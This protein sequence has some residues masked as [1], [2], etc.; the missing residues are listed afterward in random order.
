MNP[1]AEFNGSYGSFNT[2]KETVKVGTGLINNHWAFDARLSNIGTDGYIDRASSALGSYYLQGAYY[3]DNT[4]IKLISFA[5]KERTYHA[6][7]YASKDQ[8]AA[9]GRT[10]NSCGFM[11]MEDREGN[12]Y[13]PEI[14]Y[15]YGV[16]E[17]SDLLKKGA[18]F[19]FYNDQTDNY[20]QK[21]YQLL[22][23]HSF[24]PAWHLN[25]GLHY[26]KGDGYYQE[27]KQGR[28]LVQFGLVPFYNGETDEEGNPVLQKKSDL[29]RKKAMDNHFGGGIFSLDYKNDR[30]SASLG[31]A[32]NRYAGDHF[33]RVMWVKNYVGELDPDKDYYRSTVGKNDGSLYLKAGYDLGA[34]VSTYADMQYRHITYKINGRNDKW[35]AAEEQL[36]QLAID[37]KFGFFNPKAGLSWQIDRNNRLYGSFSVAHKEPTRNNYTDG[38]LKEHPKAERLFDYELGYN[39]ANH[40]LNLSANLY[41][42]DYK[43]Q[44]VL[45]G[46]MNE[47]GEAVAANV[48]DSY[49]MGVELMAGV[50][51]PCGF[52]WDINA[53]LS[54]NR[55]KNFTETLYE[56]EDQSTEAWKIERGDTPISFS[57]DFILNNRFG[58]SYRGFEA[59]LQSQYVSKQYMTNAKRDDQTLDA[60]FVSNLSLAYTFKLRGVKSVT[61]GCTVY[62]LFNEEY[63]NNGFAGSG[64]SRND[65][66]EKERYSYA[67]YAA[68]AGTNVLAHIAISF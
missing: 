61:V 39:F 48:P 26:T 10:F 20:I 56:W 19:H 12:V 30:L 66:G 47:I 28:K 21:N 53:T 11:F 34:G 50:K 22:L 5:G 4:S 14:D 15:D 51:L 16:E 46:E 44:L 58:Y 42:M 36:Q 63:E 43:D 37:E 7:N 65:N 18:K 49:R 33:G 29:I 55:V 23:N 3:H 68:Q 60:Y 1:Y 45:T 57:P 52:Q 27:Y 64:Y 59:A 2:H 13:Q 35:N 6:W 38:L 32:L 8:M 17:A 41:Y 40:W 62:N 9:F 54:R 25:M 31:G 67:V 24:S